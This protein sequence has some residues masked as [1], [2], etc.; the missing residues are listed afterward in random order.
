MVGETV[1]EIRGMTWSTD[2]GT[3]IITWLV[4]ELIYIMQ[5]RQSK[6]N[7]NTNVASAAS[8]TSPAVLYSYNG[9]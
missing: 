3:V 4:A 1:I 8:T 5:H 6:H 9:Q 7:R 2:V